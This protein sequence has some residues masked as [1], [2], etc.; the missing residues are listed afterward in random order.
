MAVMK[1]GT[2]PEKPTR[3]FDVEALRKKAESGIQL[4]PE[5]EAALAADEARRAEEQL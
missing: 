1:S 2:Q 5:A 4:V 3:K